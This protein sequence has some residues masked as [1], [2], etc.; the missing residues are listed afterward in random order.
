MTSLKDTQSLKNKLKTYFIINPDNRLRSLEV[1]SYLPINGVREWK[2]YQPLMERIAYNSAQ[3]VK[4][5]HAKP[6]SVLKPMPT[7]A[8]N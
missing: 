7:L 3:Q 8:Q 5:I 1:A 6:I 4:T 2:N